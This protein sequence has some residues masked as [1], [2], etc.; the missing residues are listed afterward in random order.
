MRYA[1]DRLHGLLVRCSV[2]C[3]V[4]CCSHVRC[5]AEYFTVIRGG[6]STGLLPETR[7]LFSMRIGGSGHVQARGSLLDQL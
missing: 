4:H 6:W 1:L 7:A 3:P 5:W 2:D